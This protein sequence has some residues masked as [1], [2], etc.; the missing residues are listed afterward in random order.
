MKLALH[1]LVHPLNIYAAL[2]YRVCGDVPY[3]CYGLCDS[4][5]SAVDGA[6][7]APSALLEGQQKLAELVISHIDHPV[8]AKVLDLGCGVGT[9]VRKLQALGYHATGLDHN[10]HMVR[11]AQAQASPVDVCQPRWINASVAEF[12]QSLSGGDDAQRFDVII[13][14]NSA[15]YDALLS[16][17]G[18]AAS[19]LAPGGQ[20]LVV[21][22][23]ATVEPDSHQPAE[24][25]VLHHALALA[26]RTGLTLEAER[27]LSDP[28]AHFITALLQQYDEHLVELSSL[29][30]VGVTALADVREALARDLSRLKAG[31]HSHRLLAWRLPADTNSGSHARQRRYQAP[32]VQVW[33]ATWIETER[34]RSVFESSFDTAFAPELW[35]WKYDAGRSASV[36]ALRG[37][38]PVAH[39]GG[40]RRHIDYFGAHKQAVQVCDV[41]VKPDERSFFSRHGLFFKTAAAM[42]EQHVGYQ[43]PQLLG[44]GFPNLKA[45]HVAARLGLYATTDELFSISARPDLGADPR[46]QVEPQA[47]ATLPFNLLGRWWTEMREGFRDAIIAHRDPAY[48]YYRYLE[49]PGLEYDCRVVRCD[50]V[51]I[52]LAIVRDHGEYDLLMDVVCAPD[53]LAGAFRALSADSWLRGRLLRFWATGGQLYRLQGQADK[54][55]CIERM[56][57]YVPCNVWSRGPSAE[58]LT[59][60]W[61]LTAGDTDFL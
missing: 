44:F 18:A 5:D 48:L 56:D 59:G 57:V 6:A 7:Y 54:A 36:V 20:L 1:S 10:P 21:E 60:A 49:R 51:P 14:Q 39:Y 61:W 2:M 42:L 25:P 23:F 45:M 22:E 34:Y 32:Q 27:D 15:R 12:A 29:T 33:P 52:A 8:S 46:W 19:L 9:L 47:L 28:T 11:I 43:A 50:E 4:H 17:I 53:K 31:E 30:G 40:I 24:L 58:E 38:E 41:M 3:L 37:G 26:E 16:V 35:R 13:L 55:L